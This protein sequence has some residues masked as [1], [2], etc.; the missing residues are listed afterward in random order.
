M[1]KNISKKFLEPHEVPKVLDTETDT[2]SDSSFVEV[3]EINSMNRGEFFS[4]DS[5]KGHGFEPDQKR[6]FQLFFG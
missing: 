5:G 2:S 4:I 1:K 6:F 3:S